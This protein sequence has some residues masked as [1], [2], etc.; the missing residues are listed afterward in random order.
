KKTLDLIAAGNDHGNRFRQLAEKAGGGTG[1]V[2]EQIACVCRDG[3][4]IVCEVSFQTFSDQ[5]NEYTLAVFHDITEHVRTQEAL[6][7]N[8]EKYSNLLETIGAA[9]FELDPSGRFTFFN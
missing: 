3:R 1:P 6:K 5:G 8:D 7:K 2:Q 4:N 9:Y